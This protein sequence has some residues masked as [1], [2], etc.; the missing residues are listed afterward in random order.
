MREIDLEKVKEEF[1]KRGYVVE[2]D[3]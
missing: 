1:R 2:K 3:K